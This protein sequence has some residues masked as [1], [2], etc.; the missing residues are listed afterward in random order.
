MR[1]NFWMKVAAV[2]LA[3]AMWLFVMSKG[4]TEVSLVA[5]LVLE[6]IPERLR[7]KEGGAQK[8]VLSIKGHERFIE[9]LTSER[10]RVSLDL[11]DIKI[12]RNSLTIDHDN[13]NLPMSLRVLSIVP[14]SVT[15]VAEEKP[16][17]E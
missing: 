15:I 13:V 7:V 9:T 17:T 14:S 16:K 8:I 6:N 3:L 10:I 1:K 2:V 11:S 4:Q 5:P 12:G